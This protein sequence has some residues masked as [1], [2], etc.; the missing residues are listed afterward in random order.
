[1]SLLGLNYL[2]FKVKCEASIGVL[3]NLRYL[4]WGKLLHES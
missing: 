1:M 4:I 3:M 2:M